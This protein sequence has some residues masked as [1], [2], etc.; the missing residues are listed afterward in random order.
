MMKQMAVRI[1]VIVLKVVV[2]LAVLDLLIFGLESDRP[3]A[4]IHTL[5]SSIAIVISLLLTAIS[6]FNNRGSK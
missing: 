4:L 6:M 2:I 3:D 5:A 1:V